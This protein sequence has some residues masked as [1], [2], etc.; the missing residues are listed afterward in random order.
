MHTEKHALIQ[1]YN[2]SSNIIEITLIKLNTVVYK[3]FKNELFFLQC[4]IITAFGKEMPDFY[5]IIL[6]LYLVIYVK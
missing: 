6:P 5:K 1:C 4:A 2:Y 3:K